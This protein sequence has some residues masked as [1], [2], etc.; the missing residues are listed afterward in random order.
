MFAHIQPGQR[1]GGPALF[2]LSAD[3]SPWRLVGR[4]E[5]SLLPRLCRLT[6]HYKERPHLYIRNPL[7]SIVLEVQVGPAAGAVLP[8]QQGVRCPACSQDPGT[9]RP[10]AACPAWNSWFGKESLGVAGSVSACSTG[11][12]CLAIAFACRKAAPILAWDGAG[13]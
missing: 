8:G 10:C 7:D 6:G 2:A 5:P 13:H 3:V 4:P 1:E 12:S 11:T 9:C